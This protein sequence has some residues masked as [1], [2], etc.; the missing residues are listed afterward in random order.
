MY[1]TIALILI[2]ATGTAQAANINDLDVGDG[3]YLEGI[4][5]DELVYVIRIDRSGHRVKVRR[6]TDGTT[7][8]VNPA[9]LI[10]REASIGNDV[11]RVAIGV[12]L[13]VCAF[14]PDSCANNSS[15]SNRQTSRTVSTSSSAAKFYVSNECEQPVRV[16]FRYLKT[17]GDWTTAAWWEFKGN[18]SRYLKFTDGNFATT[19]NTISYYYAE[20]M[21]RSLEWAGDYSVAVNERSV[22]MR[23]LNN[24]AGDTRLR[25]TCS[26]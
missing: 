25:L 6:S 8:W 11:G 19:N 9:K 22:A 2:V 16:A 7:K 26:A 4:F 14:D 21:N 1:K 15:G 23:K 24:N 5:S 18:S 20:T 10:S 3:V 13:A 12:A 17:N